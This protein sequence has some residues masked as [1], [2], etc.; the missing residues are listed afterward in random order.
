MEAFLFCYRKR[1]YSYM[2]A[3]IKNFNE[4]AVNENRKIVLEIANTALVAIDT[5]K[6]VRERVRLEDGKLCIK[7]YLCSLDKTRKIFVIGAGK[8]A[9]EA[10]SG[11]E[12]ILGDRLEG[13][14]VMD[15]HESHRCVLKKIECFIGTHPLPSEKNIEVTQ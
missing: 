12:E 11:L 14:I 6:N 1:Y 13:G 9:M 5:Q 10:A 4:L 15:V 8:C 3:K 2:S 7:D